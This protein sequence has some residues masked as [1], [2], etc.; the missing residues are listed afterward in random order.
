MT[1]QR[2]SLMTRP[3]PARRQTLAKQAEEMKAHYNAT[4]EER[5]RRQG[6]RTYEYDLQDDSS[7]VSWQTRK[8]E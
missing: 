8:E 4:R 2:E 6:G 5:I 7:E 3:V 1:E